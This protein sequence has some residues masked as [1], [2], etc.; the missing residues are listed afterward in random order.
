MLVYAAGHGVGRGFVVAVFR[1]G[2]TA[3]AQFVV[4]LEVGVQRSDEFSQRNL[5]SAEDQFINHVQAVGGVVV[6]VGL[7]RAAEVTDAAVKDAF[8]PGH[9]IIAQHRQIQERRLATGHRVLNLLLIGQ[10]S[11]VRFNNR[12]VG[13]PDLIECVQCSRGGRGHK[14][15]VGARI[16]AAM[17]GNLQGL[18]QI[19]HAAG[20]ADA[21]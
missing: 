19:D 5:L 6:A 17:Q 13:T 11:D 18:E 21:G 15:P 16:A 9:R 7:Q 10:S 3:A 20:R 4:A 12:R 8:A 1:H 2:Q 14:R